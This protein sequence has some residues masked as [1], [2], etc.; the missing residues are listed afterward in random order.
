MADAIFEERRLAELYDL[1]DPDRGDLD[2]YVGMVDEFGAH[3]VLDIGCG[4]GILACLLAQRGK[5]VTGVDPAA[6]SLDVARGKPYAERVRWVLG[7]AM[8][9]PPLQLDLATMTG[10]VAQVFVSDES[11]AETLRAVGAALRRGGLLVFESRVPEREG[12][13]EWDRAQ[14]Y[15]RIELTRGRAVSTWVDVTE[16]SLPLVSFQTT[17]AFEPDGAVLISNSTLRFRDRTELHHSL[18][19]AGFVVKGVRDAGDRPGREFVFVAE[20]APQVASDQCDITLFW[21]SQAGATD[22]DDRRSAASGNGL[23]SGPGCA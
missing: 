12:W 10:N 22:K 15:Q 4:T 7:D 19:A 16:V 14:S 13:R 21:S 17:F 9:L 6:A 20:R 5:Q 11:W 3:S 23:L 1:L 18:S 8:A 2:A